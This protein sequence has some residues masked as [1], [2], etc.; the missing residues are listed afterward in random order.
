MH[1]VCNLSSGTIPPL[2]RRS[3]QGMGCNVNVVAQEDDHE[4][5]DE[6]VRICQP[7]Q[8]VAPRCLEEKRYEKCPCVHSTEEEWHKHN[9]HGENGETENTQ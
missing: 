8:H 3:C 1:V 6:Q 2:Q 7:R 9:F 4:N 5:D